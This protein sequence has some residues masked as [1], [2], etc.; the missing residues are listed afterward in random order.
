MARRRLT[1]EQQKEETRRRLL[2]AATRVLA[3]RGYRAATV[4]AVAEEAGLTKGAVYSQFEDKEDLF[5]ACFDDFL[6]RRLRGLAAA[7]SPAAG[8]RAP[9]EVAHDVGELFELFMGERLEWFRVFVE[10]LSHAVESDSLR[11][12]LAP[13]LAEIQAAVAAIVEAQS[14]A[15]G[16]PLPAPAEH[17]AAGALAI[18]EGFALRRLADPDA[19]TEELHQ[20]LLGLFFGGIVALSRAKVTEEA[21]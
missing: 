21:G 16:L 13:R 3:E 6:R 7:G 20:S 15:L 11:A 5:F 4:D 19:Y 17:I 2:Q 14:K 12:R 18:T 9:G 10:F 8:R 1:R